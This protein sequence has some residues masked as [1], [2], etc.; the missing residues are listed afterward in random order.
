MKPDLLNAAFEAGGAVLLW[1]NVRRLLADGQVKG[2]SVWPVVFYS[3][4]GY[5]NLFYYPA[6]GQTLS[7]IAGIGVAL[8]NT[9]WVILA[10]R[11]ARRGRS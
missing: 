3:A 2:V 10:L 1:L 8:A 5:W 9:V 11:I 7:A 6:V 4:W